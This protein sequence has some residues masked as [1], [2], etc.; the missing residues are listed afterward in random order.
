VKAVVGSKKTPATTDARTQLLAPVLG[1]DEG[2]LI[3]RLLA[4]FRIDQ[5]PIVRLD[6]SLT[7]LP[8]LIAAPTLRTVAVVNERVEGFE[9]VV[10]V[11]AALAAIVKR[12]RDGRV[13]DVAA[14]LVVAIA[15]RAFERKQ[16]VQ[17][18][19]GSVVTLSRLTFTNDDMRGEVGLLTGAGSAKPVAELVLLHKG[20]HLTRLAIGNFMGCSMIAVV[21]AD[22][23]TPTTNFDGVV[24]DAKL[25]HVI[26][27]VRAARE[28]LI[29]GLVD[30]AEAEAEAGVEGG[31]I[32]S[33]MPFR[34]R[35]LE[36]L[37]V[38]HTDRKKAFPKSGLGGRIA[39]LVFFPTVSG[40]RV[41]LRDQ[42]DDDGVRYVTAPVT[43][44]PPAFA[45]IIV[46]ASAAER[47]L[48]EKIVEL[49]DVEKALTAATRLHETK[50]RLL[51]LSYDL[52]DACVVQHSARIGKAEVRLGLPRVDPDQARLTL[53]V[54]HEGLLVETLGSLL[55]PCHGVIS[56]DNVV[57]KDMRSARIDDKLLQSIAREACTL[58]GKAIDLFNKD[59]DDADRQVLR[60]WFKHGALRFVGD[61]VSKLPGWLT[62]LRMRLL[63]VRAFPLDGGFISLNTAIQEQPPALAKLLRHHGLLRAP[64][65][66]P[67]VV[68]PLRE[69]PPRRERLREP[70]PEPEPVVVVKAPEP[71]PEPEPPPP[72][73]PPTDSEVLQ[74]RLVSLIKVVRERADGLTS[75]LELHRLRV[76][77][78]R[79]KVIAR[80]DAGAVVVDVTHP[81]CQAALTSGPA[82]AMLA[83]VVVT[84]VNDRLESVTDDDE[85]RFL[86]SLIAHART[87]EE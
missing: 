34:A 25:T 48:M 57:A 11:P 27:R 58:W 45:D 23:V 79:G 1:S 12:L 36:R 41:A 68:V 87:L 55:V 29:G 74:Q 6:A 69:D 73:P 10:I 19:I 75:D 38:S 50:K 62:A 72:P 52:V 16:N 4:E 33:D 14:A 35:L 60:A 37:R 47:E 66:V 43:D 78:S 67:V 21:D 39:D 84:R 65:V 7:S 44:P 5:I 64:P 20:K 46:I 56:G 26:E 2:R 70:E 28:E 53:R 83:S 80:A 77:K 18:V 22:D 71:E 76:A 49:D 9:D 17:P 54:G 15:Q 8:D 85:R 32:V 3:E 86:T 30:V 42:G 40:A 24:H 13:D 82:L 51:P 63:D 59:V 61:D 31:K 81:L